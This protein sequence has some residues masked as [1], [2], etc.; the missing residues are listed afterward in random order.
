MY[1]HEDI[2]IVGDSF[3]QHRK[4]G[5]WP[6]ILTEMLT[7]NKSVPRGKGLGGASWW[8][9]RK[10]LLKEL[11]IKTPKILIICHTEMNRIPNDYD[12]GLNTASAIHDAEN[13]NKGKL[14]G[15]DMINKN[16]DMYSKEIAQAAV[17]YYK[18]LNSSDFN[19]WAKNMWF[20]EVDD[21]CLN[22]EK[23][24]HLHSFYDIAHEKIHAFKNGM[25]AEE[26]LWDISDDKRMALLDFSPNNLNHFTV[27]NNKK[28]AKAIFDKI[29]DY[30]TILTRFNFI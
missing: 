16:Y 20:K 29:N 3:C 27:S 14:W 25:T 30:Q 12:F 23:T 19:L 7:N 18:Y 2:L 5:G 21:L 13:F 4:E 17:L 11:K 24:I 10:V 15:V 9:T 26:S 22:I 28:I 6:F 8:S 1:N